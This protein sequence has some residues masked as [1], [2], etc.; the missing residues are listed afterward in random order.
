[1]SANVSEQSGVV[2]EQG[3]VKRIRRALLS[4]TDKTNLVDFAR[5]LAGY[6]VELVSTGGTAAALRA[7]GLAVKDIS[8]LTGFRVL[9][10]GKKGTVKFESNLPL[11][12]GWEG[13][14]FAGE[15]SALDWKDTQSAQ[16]GLHLIF[17]TGRIVAEH[18]IHSARWRD[19]LEQNRAGGL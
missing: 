18:K 5:A 16:H 11:F 4:V 12:K 8:E 1:M 9:N 2:N 17:P 3:G 13:K 6:G 14:Q 15:G 7:A 19:I 10:V